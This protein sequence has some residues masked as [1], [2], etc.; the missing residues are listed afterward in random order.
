MF[1]D[2]VFI[3]AV[4]VVS[5]LQVEA[6]FGVQTPDF[7]N[8][9]IFFGLNYDLAAPDALQLRQLGAQIPKTL[10]HGSD[11]CERYRLA[12]QM[13][14]A[15]KKLLTLQSTQK[16]YLDYVRRF[17]QTE[18]VFNTY[19]ADVKPALCGDSTLPSTPELRAILPQLDPEWRSGEE[20]LPYNEKVKSLLV[21]TINGKI[22]VEEQVRRS[23]GLSIYDQ[24]KALGVLN[25]EKGERALTQ[26][27][28]TKGVLSSFPKATEALPA[29]A[30]NATMPLE[31]MKLNATGPV[32]TLNTADPVSDTSFLSR[33]TTPDATLNTTATDS[34]QVQDTAQLKCE[35]TDD[36]GNYQ[37]Q[38]EKE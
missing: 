22:G 28:N 7:L 32:T 13:V 16:D 25:V 19:K 6:R 10:L 31:S 34:R 5:L 38:E 9:M 36:Q 11:P 12:D 23:K 26:D 3:L 33:T 35:F 4:S 24:V 17:V 20:S 27:S 21:D 2:V 8:D 1:L 18:K 29:S 30:T 14:E 37:C 15:S